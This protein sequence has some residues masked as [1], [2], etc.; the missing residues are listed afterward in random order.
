MNL[1]RF[2]T[3]YGNLGAELFLVQEDIE[4]GRII[5][6]TRQVGIKLTLGASK[7]VTGRCRDYIFSSA[8]MFQG[9]LSASYRHQ[10]RRHQS[11]M[12][13]YSTV[14]CNSSAKD[15]VSSEKQ[16]ELLI[17]VLENAY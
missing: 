1:G 8:T 17:Q 16:R 9:L 5:I 13:A 10:T 7:T 3:S 4:S 15:Q 6:S 14:F 12:E 11:K 2:P